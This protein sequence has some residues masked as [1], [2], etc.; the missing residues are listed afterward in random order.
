LPELGG[1]DQR[2]AHGQAVGDGVGQAQRLALERALVLA[3]QRAVTEA[4]P[5]DRAAEG[6]ELDQDHAR[7]GR[8]VGVELDHRHAL[9]RGDASRGRQVRTLRACRLG[10]KLVLLAC[11][12]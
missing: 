10:R 9:H 8:H 6:E 1:L 11:H 12:A 4:V 7:V 3:G 2:H 5:R